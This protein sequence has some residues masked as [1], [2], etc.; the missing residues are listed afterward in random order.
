MEKSKN[1]SIPKLKVAKSKGNLRNVDIN[2]RDA[3][4]IMNIINRN[5]INERYKEDWT[6]DKVSLVD[7]SELQT[8]Y[9]CKKKEFKENGRNQRELADHY[10]FLFVKEMVLMSKM[11]KEGL[12][13]KK[14]VFNP[15]G[16]NEFGIYICKYPDVQ[17]KLP[18]MK[19]DESAYIIIFKYMLG[20]CKAI[21]PQGN[22]MGEPAPNYDSTTSS[23]ATLINDPPNILFPRSQ[24]YLYEYDDDALPINRP[25]HCLPVAVVSFI[26]ATKIQTKTTLISSLSNTTSSSSSS[27]FGN[28]RR[29][30]DQGLPFRP[31]TYGARNQALKRT[32]LDQSPI[33]IQNAGFNMEESLQP[34]INPLIMKEGF[35][36]TY[37]EKPGYLRPELL[38]DTG[39]KSSFPTANPD[40]ISRQ[41]SIS[42]PRRSA[43]GQ[44]I[45][46]SGSST[47][48]ISSQS[49]LPQKLGEKPLHPFMRKK[50]KGTVTMSTG[51][52]QMRKNN[53]IIEKLDFSVSDTSTPQSTTV[54]E[55]SLTNLP[56]T[57][58]KVE[59]LQPTPAQTN[60]AEMIKTVNKLFGKAPTSNEPPK[61]S[62][63]EMGTMFGPHSGYDSTENLGQKSQSCSSPT[64]MVES[65]AE[66]VSPIKHE[67]KKDTSYVQSLAAQLQNLGDLQ[68]VI[69]KFNFT[70]EASP[71]KISQSP[72]SHPDKNI[73][74]PY[75]SKSLVDRT[76]LEKY[77]RSKICDV[78]NSNITVNCYGDVDYRQK[79]DPSKINSSTVQYTQSQN[80]PRQTLWPNSVSYS[81]HMSDQA[82]TSSNGTNSEKT[83]TKNPATN[84]NSSHHLLEQT[85]HSVNSAEHSVDHSIFSTKQSVTKIEDTVTSNDEAVFS[86][87]CSVYN[88]KLS[89]NEHP[90]ADSE[91]PSA[92]SEHP[93]ANSEKPVANSENPSASSEH[94]S[95]SSE[96]PVAINEPNIQ[97]S[98]KLEGLYSSQRQWKKWLKENQL[99]QN[100]DVNKMNFKFQPKVE[101]VDLKRVAEASLTNC[102]TCI[103]ERDDLAAYISNKKHKSVKKYLEH[104]E[105]FKDDNVKGNDKKMESVPVEN[106]QDDVLPAKRR[107]SCDDK[108]DNDVKRLKSIFESSASDSKYSWLSDQPILQNDLTTA[109]SP[110]DCCAKDLHD[111]DDDDEYSNELIIDMKPDLNAGKSTANGI[112]V[113]DLSP[114]KQSDV[115][116]S[117][118]TIS[119][120]KLDT[121]LLEQEEKPSYKEMEVYHT[122]CSSTETQLSKT[123]ESNSFS[124]C[125]DVKEEENMDH[126]SDVKQFGSS[127]NKN[128]SSLAY[129]DSSPSQSDQ[130]K[131]LK[132]PTPSPVDLTPVTD[133]KPISSLEKVHFNSSEE[134]SPA[135]DY[136]EHIEDSTLNKIANGNIMESQNSCENF[137]KKEP[138]IEADIP[139]VSEAYEERLRLI[140]LKYS[141]PTFP[142]PPTS[143]KYTSV[144]QELEVIRNCL[145][146]LSQNLS[147]N[148][149]SDSPDEET[150]R[151]ALLH[152][153]TE[154]I[155]ELQDSH[156]L[157]RPN[158]RLP[159]SLLFDYEMNCLYATGD[160]FMYLN[161]FLTKQLYK[162]L[163]NIKHDILDAYKEK[164][165]LSGPSSRLSYLTDH[166]NYLLNKRKILIRT[167]T[168]SVKPNRLVYLEK[169]RKY[170]IWSIEHMEQSVMNY[171]NSQMK[172]L[173]RLLSELTEHTCRIRSELES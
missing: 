163:L 64:K 44:S 88:R 121:S 2:S 111:D 16:D 39:V 23:L 172:N 21:P 130:P 20:R 101:L 152:V 60:M 148:Q 113:C 170:Y 116:E 106:N 119:S 47:N 129:S 89:S 40:M 76:G 70:G 96:K 85:T 15:L 105:L 25:R 61:E 10:G 104:I 52:T 77:Q 71:Q 30:S 102:K 34:S 153:E 125:S 57:P 84:D 74:D 165:N 28:R 155:M 19:H 56:V 149:N 35:K 99:V 124:N 138:K 115:P 143:N 75:F 72:N 82:N 55:D 7:N 126:I 54:E 154:L 27:T 147:C 144:K 45:Y 145:E 4:E 103:I 134:F 107:N 14:S 58:P 68:D 6:I 90:V 67:T 141:C 26:K 91:Q 5:C 135:H 156:F 160:C 41:S 66:T 46:S 158:Q 95:A 49:D 161:T 120:D 18:S 31:G 92:S 110:N 167:L 87:E 150:L 38:I 109:S 137:Y 100:K 112:Q 65:P 80:D 62:V 53:L 36:D 139:H 51:Q 159:P 132:S 33:P 127:P 59:K 136:E 162:S 93:S 128:G 81:Q 114:H 86:S 73:S 157:Y 3:I 83:I 94:P 151:S 50:K 118:S 63:Q 164:Q 98:Q 43:H 168:G 79:Q 12:K 131:Q 146:N 1:F 169:A 24:I 123:E 173:N 42:D 133:D 140:K 69:S 13:A 29:S 78:D 117:S 9:S 32:S 8:E 142:L 122:N 171:D 48:S 22:I 37:N 108:D 17:L 11:I 166:L 97:C